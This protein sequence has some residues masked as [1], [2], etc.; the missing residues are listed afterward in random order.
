MGEDNQQLIQHSTITKY[1]TNYN[2]S[3]TLLTSENISDV[4]HYIA[5]AV[6]T[7]LCTTLYA[8]LYSSMVIFNVDT[9]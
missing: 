1:K 6:T 2:Y 4:C 3:F 7:P 9:S 8:T 5:Q